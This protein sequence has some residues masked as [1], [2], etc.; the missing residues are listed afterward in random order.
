M[1]GDASGLLS[2]KSN[3]SA[4]FVLIDTH[5]Q[6]RLYQRWSDKRV[7]DMMNNKINQY[8]NNLIL[9]YVPFSFIVRGRVH[10]TKK[11][12]S[13]PPWMALT[14]FPLANGSATCWRW[15]W[16][17]VQF[18][19]P[20][21]YHHNTNAWQVQTYKLSWSRESTALYLRSGRIHGSMVCLMCFSDACS[22]PPTWD[23][24]KLGEYV[25]G[26]P[27]RSAVKHSQATV[28]GIPWC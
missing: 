13:T 11:T 14:L 4:L 22:R 19:F 27:F 2:C 15:Y 3:G 26:E 20:F 6:W 23:D 5:H 24:R 10:I 21:S 9:K 16:E 17:H 18:S 8:H 12:G 7:K 1:M 28:K 25:C